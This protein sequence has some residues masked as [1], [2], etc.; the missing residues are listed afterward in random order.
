MNGFEKLQKQIKDEKDIATKQVV[1]YLVTREDLE[2]DYLNKEK[3]LAQ[4]KNFIKEKA[5]K[6]KQNGWAYITDPVVLSWAVMYYSLPNNFLNIKSKNATTKKE[7]KPISDESKNNVI[8]L[9]KAKKDIE[10]KKEISQLSLF[11]GE[12]DDKN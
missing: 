9:E 3:S 10:K 2:E 1:E 7:V 8:S 11:G 6:Y 12:A 5:S 4:M